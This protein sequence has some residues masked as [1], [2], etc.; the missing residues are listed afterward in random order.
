MDNKER[1]RLIS[2][3]WR[4]SRTPE[5]R[6][7]E[8]VRRKAF[9]K[10]NAIRL[11]LA[12]R[13]YYEANREEILR[14]EKARNAVN[15]DEKNRIRRERHANK[16]EE[17]LAFERVRRNTLQKQRKQNDPAYKLSVLFRSR[18]SRAIKEGYGTKSYKVIELLGCDWVTAKEWIE[19]QWLVGM[20]WGN[21]GIKTWHID[22]KIPVSSFDMTDPDQQKKCFH[23]T[24][25]QPL[26]AKDN[27]EKSNKIL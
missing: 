24:N 4:D 25:L 14:K 8:A 9:K 11:R 10:Q 17:Q 18:I 1:K 26:W 27:M 22:H 2:K 23:Y 16:S 6:L 19:S 12:K 7:K 3:A 21:H 15:K 13:K 5:Q 20:V